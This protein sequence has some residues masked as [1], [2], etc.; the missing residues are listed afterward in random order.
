MKTPI[1]KAGGF[2]FSTEVALDSLMDDVEHEWDETPGASESYFVFTAQKPMALSLL[3]QLFHSHILRRCF[4]LYFWRI[5]RKLFVE[6][7]N[8]CKLLHTAYPTRLRLHGI[9]KSRYMT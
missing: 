8:F 6:A 2:G 5:F 4:Y 7:S 9:Y 1:L 3:S